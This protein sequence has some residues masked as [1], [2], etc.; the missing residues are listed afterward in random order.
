MSDSFDALSGCNLALPAALRR[1]VH[2]F[3]Q[4]HDPATLASAEA[5]R[6]SGTAFLVRHMLRRALQVHRAPPPRSLRGVRVYIPGA[7]A[8]VAAL[9]TAPCPQP[10]I[11]TPEGRTWWLLAD[12]GSEPQVIARIYTVQGRYG[13]EVSTQGLPPSVGGLI[14]AGCSDG[15]LTERWGQALAWLCT[16]LS[17]EHA[18]LIPRLRSSQ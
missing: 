3:Y 9:A 6:G 15:G 14:M 2:R 11:E 5:G 16:R 8:R 18:V 1:E 17:A 4:R 13:A 12:L 10:D 7:T